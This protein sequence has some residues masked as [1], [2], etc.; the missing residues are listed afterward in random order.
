MINQLMKK[1]NTSKPIVP[2]GIFL[3]KVNNRN[4]RTRCEIYSNLTI[5][6]PDRRYCRRP[7]VFIIN[8]EH[9]SHLV[10]VFVLLTLNM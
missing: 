1:H 5:K 10:L 8:F 9:V 7:G 6:T 4:T 3:V 2:A